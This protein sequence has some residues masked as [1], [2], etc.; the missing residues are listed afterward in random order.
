MENLLMLTPEQEIELLQ[1]PEEVLQIF[2]DYP[3][4]AENY[5]RVKDLPTL[6]DEY[7]SGLYEIYYDREALPVITID[8]GVIS[9]RKREDKTPPAVIQVM[10]DHDVVYIQ[11]GQHVIH[12]R[13]GNALPQVLAVLVQV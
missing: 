7:Q 10:T 13:F 5:L 3:N 4:V 2:G 12:K 11:V 8:K 9:S 1:L 6:P